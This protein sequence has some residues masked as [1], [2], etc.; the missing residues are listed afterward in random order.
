[1]VAVTLGPWVGEKVIQAVG[2]FRLAMKAM[3]L[4]TCGVYLLVGITRGFL[5][6]ETHVPKEK[7]SLRSARLGSLWLAIFVG[8]LVYST[9]F[10]STDGPFFALYAK[11]VLG[12]SESGV[13]NA[14]FLG[15]LSALAMAIVG[16]EIVDRAGSV[17]V[18]VGSFVAMFALLTPFAWASWRQIPV[19]PGLDLLLFIVLFAP[20]ELFIIAYQ[21]FLTSSAPVEHRALHVGLVG[22]AT[23][24]FASFANLA[25]GSLYQGRGPTAPFALGAAFAAFGTCIALLLGWKMRTRRQAP[26][27][28]AQ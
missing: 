1:M 14:A 24:I 7:F 15:G 13:N 3:L 17:R 12:F 11:D 26:L 6:I 9:Y 10:L 20:G 2:D 28:P 22:T 19:P 18:L 5:L 25:G 27:S 4:V 16:G 23:G 21:K 8:I